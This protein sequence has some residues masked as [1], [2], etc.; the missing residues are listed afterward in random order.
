MKSNPIVFVF[1]GLIVL[2]AG[3]MFI[4]I[5]FGDDIPIGSTLGTNN[6][7]SI[8]CSWDIENKWGRDIGIVDDSVSCDVVV[9]SC[10]TFN[11]QS[12]YPQS[13]WPRLSDEGYTSFWVGKTESPQVEFVLDEGKQDSFTIKECVKTKGNSVTIKVAV[14][15][16]EGAIQDS[17]NKR[18]TI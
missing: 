16:A 5:I 14:Y 7:E 17:V 6:G 11:I 10:S 13:F 8:T 9:D 4:Q 1:M 12:F 2:V 15:N 3:I 18:I